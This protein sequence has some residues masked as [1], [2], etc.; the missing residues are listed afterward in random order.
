[1][2]VPVSTAPAERGF[3][4]LKLIKTNLRTT[5]VQERLTGFAILSIENDV[6]SALSI[7]KFWVHSIP[8]KVVKD[9]F[10]AS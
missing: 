10:G 2:T 4:R 9:I 1:M 7:H 6:A 5:M 3:S 8:E